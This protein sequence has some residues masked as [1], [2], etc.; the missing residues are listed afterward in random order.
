MCALVLWSSLPL[1]YGISAKT[2]FP[3][4]Y[5][6]MPLFINSKHINTGFQHTEGT[7]SSVYK[8]R[9]KSGSPC[10][11]LRDTPIHACSSL[12]IKW[13]STSSEPTHTFPRSDPT[14]NAG[15]LTQGTW[16]LYPFV[17]RITTGAYLVQINC[18]LV[19][20]IWGC[21]NLEFQNPR[22]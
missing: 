12:Y 18:F 8:D 14:V 10:V 1:S 22:L 16:L 9:C 19:F 5:C 13:H 6:I 2:R 15:C 20:L 21:L 17:L 4:L 3:L 11:S 7:S